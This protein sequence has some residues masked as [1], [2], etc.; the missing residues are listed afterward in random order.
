MHFT[1]YQMN[2]KSCVSIP[3]INKYFY[4]SW[5]LNRFYWGRKSSGHSNKPES[6]IAAMNFENISGIVHLYIQDCTSNVQTTLFF[7]CDNYNL[8]ACQITLVFRCWM[9]SIFM[10][11]V[12]R[13]AHVC[14]TVLLQ[15][16]AIFIL[17]FTLSNC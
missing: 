2:Y 15:K 1:N 5:L 3:Q 14:S 12:F 17:R 13:T 16:Y 8:N 6:L 4:Q 10:K 9:Q 7:R 11:H